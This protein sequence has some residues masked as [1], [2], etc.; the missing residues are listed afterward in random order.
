MTISDV[1]MLSDDARTVAKRETGA[2]YLDGAVYSLTPQEQ[3]SRIATALDRFLAGESCATEIRGLLTE[4]F[5]GVVVLHDERR[6]RTLLFNDML[7]RL[8]VFYTRF[9]QPVYA[10]RMGDV[11]GRI[12]PKPDALGAAQYLVFDYCIGGRTMFHG[13]SELP[14]ATVVVIG[15]GRANH[16][17]LAT[18]SLDQTRTQ[19]V[20]DNAAELAELFCEAVEARAGD[21]AVVSLSGGLDSR[22]VVGALRRRRIDFTAATYQLGA[23]GGDVH[24]AQQLA[25]AV[26]FGHEV[27]PLAHPEDL[28]HS[29]R[30]LSLMDGQNIAEMGFLLPFLE[31]LAGVAGDAPVFTGDGGDKAMPPLVAGGRTPRTDMELAGLLLDR[32]HIFRPEAAAGIAGVT[33]DDLVDSVVSVLREYP[34]PVERKFARWM[35]AE[36]AVHHV[37]TGEERNRRFVNHA[38]PFFSPRF[39][40]EAVRV[41][42]DQKAHHR[43]YAAFLGQ[44]SGPLLEVPYAN[45]GTLLTSR[46]FA[47]EE[48]AKEAVKR[49]VSPETVR[50]KILRR[51]PALDLGLPGKAL[52]EGAPGLNL[53]GFMQNPTAYSTR[54]AAPWTAY[55]LAWT[56]R[57]FT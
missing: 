26:G 40:A 30:L 6:D 38:A 16:E 1:V 32:R 51:K 34:E 41:P 5:E 56:Y 49:V 2:A 57:R 48:R 42:D 4:D 44:L 15:S 11:L 14:P 50:R 18:L 27:V 10:R 29:E 39:F 53:D 46:R 24:V 7:G 3:D 45:T 31:H 52:A 17:T 23:P 9:H 33:T 22:A 12:A 8:P 21:R 28:S 55:T 47:V 54:P 35:V 25:Q 36:R 19:S 13:V 43:L 37:Y 20:E